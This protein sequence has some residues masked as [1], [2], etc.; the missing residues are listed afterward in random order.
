MTHCLILDASGRS[1]YSVE[2]TDQ[3]E[4]YRWM[5]GGHEKRWNNFELIYEN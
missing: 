2:A 4:S 3:W 5:M 1:A